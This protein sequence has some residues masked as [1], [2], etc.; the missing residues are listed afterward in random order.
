MGEK[1]FGTAGG[2]KGLHVAHWADWEKSTVGR[3]EAERDCRWHTGLLVGKNCEMTG[4]KK[5]K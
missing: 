3:L 2:R 1:Y 4:G 5:G